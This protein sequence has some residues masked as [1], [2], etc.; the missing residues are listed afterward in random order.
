MHSISRGGNGHL[1]TGISSI[2][3][4]NRRGR[5]VTE[6][7]T[8]PW[9][10]KVSPGGTACWARSWSW[11][12]GRDSKNQHEKEHMHRQTWS[13]KWLICRAVEGGKW[14]EVQGNRR[15]GCWGRWVSSW[16]V[17]TSGSGNVTLRAMGSSLMS[18]ILMQPVPHPSLYLCPL[19]GDF[20]YPFT[21]H[22]V[23][24]PT[25]WHKFS[26]VSCFGQ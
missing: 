25:S 6:A 21:K 19:L 17:C 2:K 13:V 5:G 22:R 15:C 7:V 14:L 11:R 18:C 24:F 9:D 1:C 26:H 12:M 20:V 3:G 10:G 23:C 4:Y 8:Q 16:R